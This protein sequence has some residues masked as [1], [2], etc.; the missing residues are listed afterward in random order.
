MSSHV[1]RL[2]LKVTN[3]ALF[4]HALELRLLRVDPKHMLF[5]RVWHNL[6]MADLAFNFTLLLAGLRSVVA[7]VVSLHRLLLENFTA[8]L[9][10][11]L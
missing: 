5:Q 9:A 11:G 8:D 6:F 10:R 3:R 2:N 1:H 7:C 4:Q